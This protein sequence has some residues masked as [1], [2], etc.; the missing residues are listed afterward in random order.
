MEYSKES[1]ITIVKQHPAVLNEIEAR[2]VVFRQ[3]FDAEKR[4]QISPWIMLGRKHLQQEEFELWLSLQAKEF[5]EHAAIEKMTALM[6]KYYGQL[7]PLR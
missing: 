7:Y 6:E 4:R 1:L 2:D 3:K 5:S